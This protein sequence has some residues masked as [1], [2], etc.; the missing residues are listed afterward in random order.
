MPFESPDWRLDDLLD[1]AASGKIQ[2]PDFQRTFKW[3][4]DRIASLLAT[5]SRGYPIGV[6]MT[7]ETG[8][9]GSR[10]KWRPIEGVDA[11]GT[12]EP[13]QLLLDGQQRLTSLFQVMRSRK[14]VD[15]QDARG[16]ELRRWYY[17]DI[18]K[19][20]GAESDREEAIISVPD[21]LVIRED[22]GRKIKADYTTVEAEISS[23]MFP[24][25]LVFDADAVE[26]WMIKYLD[27][28][29]RVGQT[30]RW[31][32]FRGKVLSN[33]TKYMVPVIK[34]G[35]DTPKEAVCVV[36]EKVNTGG[37]QLDVFE[38]LTATFAGDR[39]YFEKN[40]RDFELNA[41]WLEIKARFNK[42]SVLTGIASTDV[43][44]S[45]SLLVTRQRRDAAI[46]ADPDISRAPAISCKR[47]DI[48]RLTLADYL[49]WRDAVVAAFEWAAQFL[50]REYIFRA[51]DVP[52]TS[53]L[54]P[55]AAIRVIVGNKATEHP[56][57][58]KLRRWYWSGVLGELY[59][60]TT[61]TRFGR[62]VDQIPAWI[63]GGD[64]PKTVQEASFH[65]N[66]LLTL[67]T[68]N[69]AA[70]KGLYAL[71]MKGGCV[72]FRHNQPLSIA[73]FHQLDVDI[74]H[75][76]P[77]KWCDANGIDKGRRE[78]IVN[79][80]A[81]AYDTNRMIGGAS[82]PEYL[83]S[84][85]KKTGIAPE[86]LDAIL[87]THGISAQHLRGGDFANYFSDRRRRLLKIVEEA[88]GKTPVFVS[89]APNAEL[90]EEFALE[91]AEA[92]DVEENAS[93]VVGFSTSISP[94]TVR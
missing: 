80:T 72:D 87:G 56:V 91:P 55:L 62:D 81:I 78:S 41:D 69:S 59:S 4:D 36:F 64:E 57:D 3:D 93:F 6:L 60:G 34:L 29:D 47:G 2:L 94:S 79:K 30:Q 24:L 49:A 54:V 89:E 68:R 23:G 15:T 20:L 10:F 40:G 27:C 92:S 13:E 50:S 21:D 58:A 18:A 63:S 85:E 77:V 37:I 90:P 65:E 48:L 84:I 83:R 44:Q 19:A 33:I 11:A 5:I 17:I 86:E 8:G 39:A 82:P 46:R 70:Y 26:E 51:R 9:E 75:V 88:M 61:E 16:K 38:L 28:G 71:L 43:M 1:D 45:I 67:R 22:F 7:V 42:H 53:Q 31:Q 25:R 14:P 66:R 76:F 52:Y 12:R 73:A 35:R 74:H 32:A